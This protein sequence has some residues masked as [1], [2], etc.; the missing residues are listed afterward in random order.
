MN[1]NNN[2]NNES[3]RELINN[4]IN[5]SREY[6]LLVHN[7]LAFS[8][9]N[10]ERLYNLLVVGLSNN[11]DNNDN[12]NEF[13]NDT[14]NIVDNSRVYVTPSMTNNMHRPNLNTN[15]NNINRSNRNRRAYNNNITARNVRPRAEYNPR[16]G[17]MSSRDSVPVNIPFEEALNQNN[18]SDVFLTA[19]GNNINNLT[20]EPVAVYP[21]E[22]QIN[23]ACE[24]VSFNTISN[25]INSSCPINLERFTDNSTVTQILYCGH[26]YNPTALRRWFTS[27]VRCPICRYDIRNYNPL[28][29][30]RNPYRRIIRNPNI[31]P[32]ERSVDL[33]SNNTT[34]SNYSNVNESHINEE[35]KDDDDY[36]LSQFIH[37][38]DIASEMRNNLN[39]MIINDLSNNPNLNLSDISGNGGP[40]ID[41]SYQI[42]FN[43]DN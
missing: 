35:S 15:R 37:N 39:Q 41:L 34:N 26:C 36:S 11:N 28:D 27:N 42:V 32:I 23:N 18:I 2:N 40:I 19:F 20:F 38:N 4:Y 30:I 6:L 22:Q 12:N 16:S 14:A 7:M 29:V 17:R 43:N 9:R 1:N 25:P 5:Y 10:D 8:S 13:N 3:N 21:S 24:D 31:G 33:Q